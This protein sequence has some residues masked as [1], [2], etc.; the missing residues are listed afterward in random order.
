MDVPAQ[1]GGKHPKAAECRYTLVA[2]AFCGPQ[3]ELARRGGLFVCRDSGRDV[4]LTA[5]IGIEV[6]GLAE[7][8]TMRAHIL[9]AEAEG[10]A[11]WRAW[12]LEMLRGSLERQGAVA[13]GRRVRWQELTG[14]E[15]GV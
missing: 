14:P 3:C 12:R 5:E 1:Q 2:A 6:F 4:A 10:E 13:V 9:G 8:K 7:S 15:A 11:L